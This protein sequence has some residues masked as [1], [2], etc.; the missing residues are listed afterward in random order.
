[1]SPDRD[2]SD[3]KKLVDGSKYKIT[4]LWTRDK[5]LETRGTFKGYM[6]VGKDQGL[7]IELDD[8]KEEN[9]AV[10]VIPSHM[11]LCI[12]ILEQAEQKDEDD[13]KGSSY[14]G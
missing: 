7:K 6:Y 12:D 14:F 8:P 13:D 4:S 5:I 9:N 2:C 11:V 10:R 3:F 1:M